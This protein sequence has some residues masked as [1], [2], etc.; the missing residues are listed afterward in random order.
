MIFMTTN[1]TVVLRDEDGSRQR[2]R[3][4]CERFKRVTNAGRRYK[5]ARCGRV[6]FA[7]EKQVLKLIMGSEKKLYQLSCTAR[8]AELQHEIV[9]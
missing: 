7:M 5:C 8:N 3:C 9:L 1:R 2:C 4:G 6:Y